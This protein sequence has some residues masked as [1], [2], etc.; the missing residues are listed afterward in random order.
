MFPQPGRHGVDVFRQCFCR[1]IGHARPQGKHLDRQHAAQ[2]SSKKIPQVTQIVGPRI[3]VN[4]VAPVGKHRHI[5]RQHNIMEL[6]AYQCKQSGQKEYRLG[7]HEYRAQQGRRT[8][9]RTE[10]QKPFI[11]R[12]RNQQQHQSTDKGRIPIKRPKGCRYRTRH[13]L[14]VID[15]GIIDDAADQIVQRIADDKHGYVPDLSPPWARP[16]H[17]VPPIYTGTV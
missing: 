2:I 11:A 9:G 17:I 14:H 10:H 13:F 5:R 7:L 8:G 1:L 3:P 16:F 15:I 4:I 6:N 12:L